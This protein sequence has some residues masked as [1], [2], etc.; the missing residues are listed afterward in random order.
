M[1]NI[2]DVENSIIK[3]DSIENLRNIPDKTIDV[4][5]ADPHTGCRQKAIY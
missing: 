3:G 5:F 2:G 1:F 4:I